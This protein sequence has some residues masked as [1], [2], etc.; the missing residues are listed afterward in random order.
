MMDKQR[1]I[2]FSLSKRWD[3]NRENVEPIKQ[4]FLKRPSFTSF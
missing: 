4:V 2:L 1:D 3:M